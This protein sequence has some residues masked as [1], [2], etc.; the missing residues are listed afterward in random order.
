MGRPTI[1]TA[2]VSCLTGAVLALAFPAAAFAGSGTLGNS[3]EQL[4]PFKCSDGSGD[5]LFTEF[6][7]TWHFSQGFPGT[8]TDNGF[9]NAQELCNG[10]HGSPPVAASI[11]L[12]DKL[13][14]TGV[15][16]SSCSLGSSGF[17]C[18]FSG[19]SSTN[20]WS[21]NDSRVT[22]VSHNWLGGDGVIVDGDI[23]T[24]R[25]TTTA[26]FKFGSN[27]YQVSATQSTGIS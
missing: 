1:K 18:S 14:T 22:S 13:V 15:Q 26:T 21:T 8:L 20:D 2:L 10:E 24:L 12:D 16:I 23:Y 25:E 5:N 6:D 4:S 17:S 3:R 9:S 27:Y 7:S 11:T 19:T